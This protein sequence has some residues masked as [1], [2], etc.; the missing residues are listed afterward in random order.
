MA[1]QTIPGGLW[2]PSYPKQVSGGP[3]FTFS[4]IDAADEGQAFMIRIPKTGNVAKVLWATRTVTTG[5][6]ITVRGETWDETTTPSQP[7]GTLFHANFTG[8]SV[9]ADTDDNIAV[10]TSLAAA[11]A[12][13]RGD[14]V[15]LIIKHAL[16][17]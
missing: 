13:T 2:I 11:V 3:T 15:A 12:V 7:S 6:T 17:M 4:A 16:S 10:L 14:K 1:I 8:T 5:S 9:I